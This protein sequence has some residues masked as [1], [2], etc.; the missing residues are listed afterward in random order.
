MEF[1]TK[2]GIKVVMNPASLDKA[3]KLKSLVEKALL[4]QGINLAEIFSKDNISYEEI[5]HLA[6]SVDS[7]IDVFDA[8]FECMDKS[9]YNNLKITKDVFEDETIDFDEEPEFNSIDLFDDEDDTID[10]TIP[11]ESI[12]DDD[13]DAEFDD[14][15]EI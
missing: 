5:F 11:D 6:M 15:E 4:K 7:D 12:F 9:I 8:C 2:S 14:D 3:F 13:F 1:T 10:T